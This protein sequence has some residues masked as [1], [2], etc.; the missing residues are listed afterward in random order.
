MKKLINTVSISVSRWKLK[1]K[2]NKAQGTDDDLITVNN[3]FP[4]LVKE[5]SITKYDSD[6]RIDSSIFSHEIYQYS[7]AMLKHLPKNALKKYEKTMLYRKEPVYY[8]D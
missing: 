7:D 3:I 2:S 6:K 4:H 8:N 1:G 5:I